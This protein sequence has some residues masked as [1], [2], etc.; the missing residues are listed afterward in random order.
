VVLN[1]A[2]RAVAH[3]EIGN[4]AITFMARFGGMS[5]SVSVPVAAVQA[6]YARENGQGMLL[7]DDAPGVAPAV[8]TPD[9]TP[10]KPSGPSLQAEPTSAQDASVSDEVDKNGDGDKPRPKGKPSLHVVK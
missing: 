3:L 4:D 1:L 10:A 6:I 5:H 9:T 2:P 8:R 7:A